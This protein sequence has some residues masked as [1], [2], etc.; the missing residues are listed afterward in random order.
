[1]SICNAAITA[2][3]FRERMLELDVRLRRAFAAATANRPRLHPVELSDTIA[4]SRRTSRASKWQV[5]PLIRSRTWRM[6]IGLAAALLM[7]VSLWLGQ[8]QPTL[9]A[10]VIAHIAN[11]PGSWSETKSVAAAMLASILE[12]GGVKLR[13]PL[14]LTVVY[15]RNCNFQG[16]SVPHFVVITESGPVTVTVFSHVQVNSP[17]RFQSGEYRGRLLRLNGGGLAVVSHTFLSLDRPGNEVVC[18][19]RAGLDRQQ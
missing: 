2:N 6:S 17:V 4:S 12:A 7:G 10:E 9:A 13:A 18:A 15:A 3:K 19:L 14:S 1:M 5:P 11:E 8:P 16:H